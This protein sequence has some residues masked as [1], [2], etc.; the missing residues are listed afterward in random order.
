MKRLILLATILSPLFCIGQQ[1]PITWSFEAKALDN[2]QYEIH[3]IADIEQGWYIY[4][5]HLDPDEGPIPTSILLEEGEG[6]EV[7]GKAMESGNK[8]E[9][10][11]AIFDMFI[12]KYSDQATFSRIIE[13]KNNSVTITGAIE[14]MTCDDEQ[15]LPP[16]EVPFELSIS[17]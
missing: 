10:H 15:C 3:C 17:K 4:S 13:L 2:G 8:K 1:S 12:I 6:Y 7:V 5:Q 9:G 14:F 11:D 16:T